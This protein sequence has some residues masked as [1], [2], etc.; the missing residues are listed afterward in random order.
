M[1]AQTLLKLVGL[2]YSGELEV[3]GGMEQNDVRDLA[4]MFGIRDLV[5]GQKNRRL[6][7]GRLAQKILSCGKGIGLRT[8]GRKMHDA[9]AQ[10]EMAGPRETGSSL[11]NRRFVSTGTQ[12]VNSSDK[13]AGGYFSHSVQAVTPVSAA[14]VAH[15]AD[16]SVTLQPQNITPDKQVCSTSSLV[17]PSIASGAQNA[18]QATFVQSPC[19]VINPTSTLS[20]SHNTKTSHR[21]PNN[22]SD[23]P[24][25]DEDSSYQHSSECGNSIHTLIKTRT[26]FE[27][28]ITDEQTA[29]N[30]EDAEQPPEA[31][32][33]EIPGEERGTCTER[34]THDKL[35]M[36][37]LTKMKHMQEMLKTT[38]ISIKVKH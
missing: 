34:H 21:S 26:G 35:A 14:S 12:T 3:N 25:T 22:D 6:R 27:D 5:E 36:K 18:G 30:R 33:D 16:L 10:V 20:L 13:S 24:T 28:G 37:S 4:H 17:I 11:G 7:E 8:E 15:N 19:S 2:L 38:Q 32:R 31:G 9:Q 1:K 29:D 23:S